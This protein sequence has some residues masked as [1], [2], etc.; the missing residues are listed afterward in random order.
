MELCCHCHVCLL[1]VQKWSKFGITVPEG[2]FMLDE[3]VSDI[4]YIWHKCKNGE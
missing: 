2:N 3:K 1:V 4:S